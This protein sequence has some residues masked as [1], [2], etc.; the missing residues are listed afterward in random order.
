MLALA[1]FQTVSAQQIKASAV[2]D[3][4]IIVIG[5][6]IGL[7]LEVEHPK[8]ISILFPTI[9]DT[10]TSTV[11]V[12]EQSKV[13]TTII[14]DE[15]IKMSQDIIITSFDSGVHEIPEF[16]FEMK[17]NELVDSIQTNRLRLGVATMQIDSTKGM[18]DI[19]PP[20]EAPLSLKEVAP[21]ALGAI[22]F[23]GLFFLLIYAIRRYKNNQPIF[24]RP[25]KPREPEDIIAIRKLNKVKED[26]LWQQGKSK[27][28]YSEVADT[29]REYISYRYDIPALEQTSDETIEEMRQKRVIED[30]KQFDN[31]KDI[32]MTSDLVKFAKFIPEIEKH[33]ISLVDA[34]LFV[35]KTKRIIENDEDTDEDEGI[36]VDI[37]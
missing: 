4:T 1:S 23:A 21:W 20:Y 12:I 28:F 15:T 18:V 37:K 7:H 5:D 10:I 30:A 14:D 33:D 32:L 34:Y 25:E 8:T 16:W 29:L 2:L 22:L 19:K 6:Q 3:S 31:L 11:E 13:D 9:T 17:Y 36:G 26:K 24:A 35:E 27:E